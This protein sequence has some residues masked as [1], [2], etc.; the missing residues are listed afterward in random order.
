MGLMRFTPE[1]W[2]EFQKVRNLASKKKASL[3]DMTETLK[4]FLL[5]SLMPIYTVPYDG[6]WG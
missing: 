3:M 4:L 6:L 2:K 1:G 5:K